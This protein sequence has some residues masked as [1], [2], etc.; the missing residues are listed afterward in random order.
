[1]AQRTTKA[2]VQGVLL[3]D[4]SQEHDLQAFIDTAAVII[5]RVATCATDR[6]HTLSAAE[7]E[8]IERWLAAHFYATSDRPYQNK[9]T[10]GASGGFQ[11]QTGMYLEATYY[12]QTASSLDSSGCLASIA[13]GDERKTA[14]GFWGGLPPSEQTAYTDR[15]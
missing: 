12:G 2:A 6:D 14:R 1:M 13:A 8:I 15:D 4:Y 7:L 3:Q 9:S 5:D 10:S 11:G